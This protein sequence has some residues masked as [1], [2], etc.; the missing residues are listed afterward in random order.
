VQL[1]AVA[2]GSSRIS[3][4]AL[5]SALRGAAAPF[6]GLDA[7]TFT[8]VA[9]ASGR[10]AFAAVHSAPDAAGARRYRAQHG[11]V[12]VLY[13][14]LPVEPQRRFRAHDAS[15]LLENW[16]DDLVD[17]LAGAFSLLRVDLRDD[18]AECVLDPLGL[19]QVY[20]VARPGEAVV[21][22][23][24][25][26]LKRYAGATSPDP[27]SVSSFLS[28]GWPLEH[29]TLL[30]DVKVLPGGSVHTLERGAVA[31]RRAFTPQ[32]L[33]DHSRG[34]PAP[35]PEKTARALAGA[36]AAAAE[37]APPLKCALTAG[38]DS[39]VMLGL[40]R[41]SGAPSHYY[42]LG[43]QGEID[44]EVASEIAQRLA[45]P[46]RVSAS[47]GLDRGLDWEAFAASAVTQ[48]DG[49][50]S[51]PQVLVEHADAP[52]AGPIGVKSWGVGGEIGR[53]VGAAVAGAIPGM[54]ASFA[55]QRRM[56]AMRVRDW[57][58]LVAPDATAAVRRSLDGYLAE[59][60][61]EG[62]PTGDLI[63]AFYTF[64]RIGR[65]GAAAP[66]RTAAT[67]DI[68]VPFCSREF[69]E[70]AFSF[71]HAE[72]YVEAPHWRLLTELEPELRDMRFDIPWRPQRPRRIAL[73]ATQGLVQAALARAAERRR[74]RGETDTADSVAELPFEQAWFESG[75]ASHREVLAAYPQ[76]DLWEHV[77][78][79]RVEAALAGPALDR[80]HQVEGLFR[81]VSLFWWFHARHEAGRVEVAA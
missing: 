57:D 38:R 59:R 69:I 41:A 39:R 68:F 36:M 34:A 26:A 10:M 70:Y 48:T 72:R 2:S 51:L 43:N 3:S 67:D 80:A 7:A 17:S 61:D 66:R 46:H 16:D 54:R 74:A 50:S 37:V 11:A 15:E 52:P 49:I 12:S 29:R 47:H 75:I 31:S 44:V 20:V 24:L 4:G 25:E 79:G 27:L 40:L 32:R 19:G 65:W 62:W 21:S 55:M 8:S 9:S 58:G 35:S 28:L 6:P 22:N 76:S 77:D 33:L 1:Y 60:R 63:E 13:D 73:I 5:A 30:A 42:T 56:L 45:L 53:A 81:L 71:S 64:E 78:R 23:S 14:G 18:R